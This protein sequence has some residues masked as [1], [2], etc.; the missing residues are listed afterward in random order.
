M[1][2]KAVIMRA[3][4]DKTNLA[5]AAVFMFKNR[6]KCGVTFINKMTAGN[7]PVDKIRTCKTFTHQVQVKAIFSCNGYVLHLR[8]HYKVVAAIAVIECVKLP[9]GWNR[10]LFF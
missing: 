5:D 8:A 10:I 7:L 2:H 3:L 4:N 6:F 9:A 1:R